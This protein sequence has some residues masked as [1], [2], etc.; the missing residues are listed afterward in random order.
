MKTDKF[1]KVLEKVDGRFLLGK[2]ILI[3]TYSPL[4]RFNKPAF[5]LGIYRNVKIQTR[6][7]GGRCGGWGTDQLF[8][9]RLSIKT[10]GNSHATR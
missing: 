10:Q 8:N 4:E 9:L 6:L 3:L 5:R 7:K 1:A 2:E